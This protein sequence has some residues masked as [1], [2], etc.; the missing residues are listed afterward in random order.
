MTLQQQVSSLELSRQLKEL[1]VPQKSLWYWVHPSAGWASG[2]KYKLFPINHLFKNSLFVVGK[3]CGISAFTVAELN[4][5]LPAKINNGEFRFR[6]RKKGGYE[7]YYG[8]EKSIVSFSEN[9][10]NVFAKMLIYLLE[11]ELIEL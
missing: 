11:N 9:L 7:L 2:N 6:K 4:N 3:D 10:P 8:R 1:G 5:F